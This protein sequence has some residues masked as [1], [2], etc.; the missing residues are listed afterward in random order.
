MTLRPHSTQHGNVMLYILLCVVLFAA[1]GFA[2][3]RS[4]VG[5]KDISD[6]KAD[7]IASEII[8]YAAQ[9]RQAITKLKL[10]G[11][12]DTQISFENTTDT[13]YANANSPSSGDRSCWVFDTNG[14]GMTYK[15]FTEYNVYYAI[16]GNSSMNGIGP[17]TTATDK[18]GKADLYLMASLSNDAGKK[19][20]E[21][22]NKVLGN[23]DLVPL[24]STTYL[25]GSPRFTGT[26]G[27]DLVA[28]SIS[29]FYRKNAGCNNYSPSPTISHFWYVL[30]PR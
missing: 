3:S 15:S 23:T 6:Q 17:G 4:S 8:D 11:C 16:I 18:Y 24:P 21:A 5:S 14:G 2:L 22:F 20:C 28:N 30:I 7:L 25:M 1:L 13:G 27:A 29:I 19:L 12:S 9:I 26:F 10:R